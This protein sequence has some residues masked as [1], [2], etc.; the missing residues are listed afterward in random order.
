MKNNNWLQILWR[1][2]STLGAIWLTFSII[3][4]GLLNK[5][6]E[7]HVSG[8]I[9]EIFKT[10]WNGFKEVHALVETGDGKGNVM[11]SVY[12]AGSEKGDDVPLVISTSDR[13]RG[14]IF[15]TIK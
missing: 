12:R 8:T 3:S 15:A 7:H 9:R 6:N 10:E 13:G 5:R 4:F 14:Y 11:V 2:Y 1:V